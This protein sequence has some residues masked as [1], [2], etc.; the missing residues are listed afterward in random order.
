[1]MHRLGL[2]NAAAVTRFAIDNDLLQV[3]DEGDVPRPDDFPRI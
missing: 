1:M 2:H 3:H